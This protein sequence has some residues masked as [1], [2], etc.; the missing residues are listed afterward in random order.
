MIKLFKMWFRRKP[1]DFLIC[2]KTS[3][4]GL[5]CLLVIFFILHVKAFPQKLSEKY[6]KWLHGTVRYIITSE[7]REVFLKLP[8]NDERERFINN[9]W[10]K[11]DPNPR[12][13]VNEF[14][15]EYLNRV[16]FVNKHFSTSM[17]AGMDTD[18]GM[19]Y[20]LF[21]TPDE[22]EQ[23]P[24]GEGG[25]PTEIWI[26]RVEDSSRMTRSFEIRFVDLDNTR[27][28]VLATNLKELSKDI[29]D[30]KFPGLLVKNPELMV[31]HF[32]S[33]YT[34]ETL[35]YPPW[36]PLIDA[37]YL[38]GGSSLQDPAAIQEFASLKPLTEADYRR[39]L[40]PSSALSLSSSMIETNFFRAGGNRV[41]MPITINLPLEE[42]LHERG[43]S[44]REALFDVVASLTRKGSSQTLM[45][46]NRISISLGD[47][48][49]NKI[50][51]DKSTFQ[52]C[53][54]PLPATYL[55]ELYIID[56]LSANWYNYQEELTVPNF[57]DDKLQISSM[58]LSNRVQ[59]LPSSMVPI[60]RTL[61]PYLFENIKIV[62]NV[63]RNFSPQDKLSL[64]YYIYNL[65]FDPS[66][67]KNRL[68]IE[69]LF[70]KGTRLYKR[71]TTRYPPPTPLPTRV[72]LI[73]FKLDGFTPGSY[74]LRVRA[75]DLVS[76]QRTSQNINFELR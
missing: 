43:E 36:V 27:S 18:Q 73:T 75:I 52:L 6:Q 8:T 67:G 32:K 5:I 39:S 34:L 68:A 69:Y 25:Y 55:L 54:M 72:I 2:R 38:E 45:A 30:F 33:I 37:L 23:I 50:S 40:H 10:R 20:I 57:V 35:A 62:P 51:R 44:E 3:T 49:L 31:E 17:R 21:G 7:E 19:I 76:S 71:I 42:L 64:F 66:T 24:S 16:E 41:R 74:T 58:T 1:L 61:L 65:S 46:A 14:Q 70:Y 13:R 9:F 26:Y 28:Y 4:S 47:K 22:I 29:E 48:T 15:R 12:T 56:T 60:S 11:R 53:F 59:I 63:R